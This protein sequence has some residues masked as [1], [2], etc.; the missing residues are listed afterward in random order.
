MMRRG[1]HYDMFL[2]NKQS[3]WSR[4]GEC[5]SR[6]CMVCIILIKDENLGNL[7]CYRSSIDS[8]CKDRATQLLR[9]G[10]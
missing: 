2:E 6:K 3:R 5:G 8:H 9:S 7:L 1:L 10:S 4:S